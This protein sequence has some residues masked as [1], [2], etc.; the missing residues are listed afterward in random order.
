MKKIVSSVVD[1]ANIHIYSVA[2]S[3]FFKVQ[4]F[5]FFLKKWSTKKYIGT[6]LIYFIFLRKKRKIKKYTFNHPT[7]CS[8]NV[9]IPLLHVA[10]VQ[11]YITPCHVIIASMPSRKKSSASMMT[12]NVT[13][14]LSLTIA[15]FIS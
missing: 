1:V 8:V 15:V 11:Q 2:A 4:F 12:R 10:L 13:E 14:V 6:F 3:I 7:T 9:A 5:L